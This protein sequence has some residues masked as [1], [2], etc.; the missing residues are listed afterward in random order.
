MVEC[1]FEGIDKVTAEVF[2]KQLSDMEEQ[3]PSESFICSCFE[4]QGKWYSGIL[5][6]F[7]SEG[8]FAAKATSKEPTTL[9]RELLGQFDSAIK[10]WRKNRFKEKTPLARIADQSITRKCSSTDCPLVKGLKG[11]CQ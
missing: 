7:S 6:L 4:K 10:E 8:E 1:T 5:R 11:A 9:C 2:R 3:A